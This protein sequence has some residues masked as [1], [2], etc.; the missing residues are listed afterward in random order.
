MLKQIAELKK[1]IEELKK[2]IQ[3][4][5]ET[6]DVLQS[7][8]KSQVRVRLISAAETSQSGALTSVLKF[9]VEKGSI[10]I[11]DLM[12]SFYVFDRCV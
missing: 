5:D 7:D 6:I 3:G 4:R 12:S 9:N 10:K 8:I 1:L 11:P 2:Q